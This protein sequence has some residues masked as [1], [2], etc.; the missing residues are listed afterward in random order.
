MAAAARSGEAA[1]A[2][3]RGCSVSEEQRERERSGELDGGGRVTSDRYMG[4]VVSC[5][6][7]K[8]AAG[9]KRPTLPTLVSVSTHWRAH[10]A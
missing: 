5:Y 3:D 7:Y 6:S 9:T 10:K 2:V 8:L 1:A 4:N